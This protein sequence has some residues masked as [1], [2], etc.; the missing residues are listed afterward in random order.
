MAERISDDSIFS[1]ILALVGE[2]QHLY[3]KDSLSNYDL[4][5]L[6]A[7]KIE[8]DQRWDVLRL[9]DA[10]REFGQNPNQVT[11]RPVSMVERY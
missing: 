5:R 6:E 1:Q 7:I 2:Q 3:G 8:L 10:R 9:R 11:P 4:V